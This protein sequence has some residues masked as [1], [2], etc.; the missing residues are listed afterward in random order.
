MTSITVAY[1]D[2]E[3]NPDLKKGGLIVIDAENA[4]LGRLASLTARLVRLG[5]TVHV[6]NI[7]KAVVTGDKNMV[8]QSYKLL[9]NVKTH[10][11]PYRHSM[12]RPRNPILI[13][14]K[15]V[16]NM[17]PKE[18]WLGVQLLKKVK[19]YIGVP[20]EFRSRTLIRILDCDASYLGRRKTVPLAVIAKELGWKAKVFEK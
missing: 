8:V 4:V 12:K 14:K 19:A 13:F 17:L 5:Y 2:L 9:L 1:R 7:E 20:E 10:K 11:N 18:S 3:L 16:R 15:A 6:V